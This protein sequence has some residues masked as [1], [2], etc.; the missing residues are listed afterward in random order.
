MSPPPILVVDDGPMNRALLCHQLA[1]LGLVAHAVEDAGAA[2]AAL[3]RDRYAVVLMDCMMPGI[4]GAEACRRLRA[5]EQASGAARTP[6]LA[7]SAARGDDARARC[8]AAGMDG[9]LEKPL[10]LA[11]LAAALA[12]WT[13]AASPN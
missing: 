3:A 12:P 5:L 7:L 2:L 13:G 10:S 1:R 8:L 4:D 6:V 9:Y 11:A